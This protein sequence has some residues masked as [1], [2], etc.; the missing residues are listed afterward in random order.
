LAS[1]RCRRCAGLIVIL[2]IIQWYERYIAN[3]ERTFTSNPGWLRW[4]AYIYFQF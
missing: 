4:L 3:M 2:E 1:R